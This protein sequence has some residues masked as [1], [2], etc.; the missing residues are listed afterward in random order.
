LLLDEPLSNLDARLRT[1]LRAD[2]RELQQRLGLTSIYVTHDQEEALALADRIAMMQF[3][4]IVQIG[5]PREIYAKPRSASIADFLGVSN[6]LDVDPLDN[7]TVRLSGTEITLRVPEYVRGEQLKA[8]IR[9]EDIEFGASVSGGNEIKGRVATRE[10]L[11]A[12]AVYRI[13]IAEA[14]Q[15]EVAG[16]KR[17]L[18]NQVEG[19]EIVLNIDVDA[20]QVLP[21]D[22]N[23]PRA[24]VLTTSLKQAGAK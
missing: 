8:C 24:D 4:R 3:G 2:L 11:G 12:T 9:S 23:E 18:L 21:E 7:S 10:F 6:V 22:V 19:D 15:L 13:Q 1:R 14:L 20:I 5:S 16:S 17:H